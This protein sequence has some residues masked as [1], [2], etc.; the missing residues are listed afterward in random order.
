L[1]N[2]TAV[3]DRNH[4]QNDYCVDDLMPVE[5]VAD[6]WRAFGWN[7][8]EIDGHK[9]EEIVPALEGAKANKGVP[10]LI[11]AH[12]VKG[13]GVSYMENKVEWH[14]GNVTKPLYEQ[15]MKEINARL[16]GLSEYAD[17]Q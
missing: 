8:V 5:P 4:L 16:E 13:K 9:M 14:G 10:M 15:A 17:V 12:T 2:L 6:K 3:L 11:L 7:V 1:D